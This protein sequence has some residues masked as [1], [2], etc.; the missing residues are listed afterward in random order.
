MK[1]RYALV[2][3]IL[4]ALAV[5]VWLMVSKPAP[6][7]PPRDQPDAQPASSELEPRAPTVASAIASDAAPNA[8]GIVAPRETVRDE[9]LREQLRVALAQVFAAGSSGID[10]GQASA[11]PSTTALG[12]LDPNYIRQRIREDFV[13]MASR[14]YDLLQ[15]RRP[16]FA[17]RMVLRFRITAHEQLGGIVED[18][19]V[20]QARDPDAGA[21]DGDASSAGDARAVFGDE[22]FETCVRESMMT[23]A[24]APPE[25]GGS[26]T[27]A[28]PIGLAP[29]E[30]SSAS[31][32]GR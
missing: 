26:L 12:N 17:G 20:A 8:A 10:A 2:A 6:R 11:T 13:P 15:S 16:G 21:Q 23:V 27:V 3:L 7:V 4:V 18:V 22:A 31:D 30:P 19:S 29:D 5:A 32:A 25:R 9:R 28:Y 1:P 14:C 24:F